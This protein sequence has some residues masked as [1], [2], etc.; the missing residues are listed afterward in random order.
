MAKKMGRPVKEIDFA[1]FDKLCELQCLQEEMAD[2]FE[3]SIDTLER[4]VKEKTGLTFAD[5]YG[6]KRGHGKVALRRKQMQ[7][8][9]KG[10]VTMLIWLGKQTLGQRDKQEIEHSGKNGGPIQV[11]FD[12][13]FEGV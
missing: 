4:R 13:A 5:Y 11:T 2:F 7:V 6:Q 9:L 12:K 10:N 1:L 8:A 3:V